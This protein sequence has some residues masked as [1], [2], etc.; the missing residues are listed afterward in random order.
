MVFN[1]QIIRFVFCFFMTAALT[2]AYSLLVDL[3]KEDPYLDGSSTEKV[4][5]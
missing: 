2:A 5:M 3:S 4:P 1:V